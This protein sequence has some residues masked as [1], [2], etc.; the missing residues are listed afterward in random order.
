MQQPE[1][2][3]LDLGSSTELKEF[4]HDVDVNNLFTKIYQAKL[5]K[6][7]KKITADD[8]NNLIKIISENVY[9]LQR[10]GIYSYTSGTTYPKDA[11]VKYN[12][13]LYISEYETSSNP[14]VDE[15]PTWK[16]YCDLD[17]TPYEIYTDLENYKIT[18]KRQLDE[19]IANVRNEIGTDINLIKLDISN[20]NE[21]I[22]EIFA[23]QS[24]L[25]SSDTSINSRLDIIDDNIDSLRTIT[26]QNST[27]IITT[28]SQ[29][30]SHVAR[31]NTIES[32]ANVI[33]QRLSTQ[34]TSINN[35]NT[36]ITSNSNRITTNENQINEIK[37]DVTE[38]Y[39]EFIEYKESNDSSIN[40]INNKINDSILRL[41]T[42]IDSETQSIRD[43][44]YT[45]DQ[46]DQK[47]SSVYNFKGSVDSFD[48]L[49]SDPT[50][51]DVYDVKSDG[52]N[53]AWTGTEWNSLGTVVNVPKIDQEISDLQ[54]DITNI[55]NNI[56]DIN[57]HLNNNDS[58]INELNQKIDD[59]I[60][61][62]NAD[63]NERI[64]NEVN[65]LNAEDNRIN[66]R[67]DVVNTN[68]QS[69]IN[70]LR[71]EL[72]NEITSKCTSLNNQFNSKLND[73]NTNIQNQI[74]EVESNLL[75]LITNSRESK[76]IT[77]QAN[78]KADITFD[79]ADYQLSDIR[80]LVLDNDED[81]VTYGKYINSEGCCTIVFDDNQYSIYN[82]TDEDLQF[83][84][85][86]NRLNIN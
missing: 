33:S 57:L 10:G 27:D 56:N 84:I 61:D 71:D 34:A 69:L 55:E 40:N 50:V 8:I 17:K 43:T 3:E 77:I 32:N 4:S 5:N 47:L 66:D 46:I 79:N 24:D 2:W 75:D 39:S 45:R 68:L 52:M 15:N 42:K 25:D 13:K 30:N 74:S 11:I 51:G 85:I 60:N 35:L 31:M 21:N 82:E 41:D 44:T 23:K 20:I 1:V 78:S 22:N 64:T 49:P 81:S 38:K 76:T 58:S 6:A 12:D 65:L 72:M 26:N 83:M 70:T 37:S 29:L 53:Y 14:I 16:L 54:S 9:F 19:S 80:V 59:D 63:L 67:I 62:I 48:Y 7:G 18:S 73:L 86:C 36:L 28:K